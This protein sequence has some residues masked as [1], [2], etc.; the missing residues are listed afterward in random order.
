MSARTLQEPPTEET[1]TTDV[2]RATGILP[3]ARTERFRLLL[4]LFLVYVI[5]GSTYL[6]I[7]LA[8]R[9]LP[10]F[11]MSG[12][13]FLIAG[14]L[15]YLFLRVRGAPSPRRAEW[16][17]AFLVGAFLMGGN[18]GVAFSEQWV[19]S[20]LA[21]LVVAAVPLWVAL[22]SGFWGQWPNRREWL[23][24]GLGLVGIGLLNMESNLRAN[25]LGAVALLLGVVCWA[26]G[27]AWGRHLRLPQGLMASAA[28][29][30]TGGALVLILGLLRGERLHHL[31][32]MSS[33]LALL[34]L[35]GFG[36]LLA[37]S[38]Y[39]YLLRHARPALATSYAYANP[40]IAV[41][42]GAGLAGEKITPVGL[43]ALLVILA[44]VTLMAW[45]KQDRVPRMPGRHE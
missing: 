21:S 9:D 8:V 27:S 7:R 26:W 30:L 13:R 24:L 39:D 28:E 11:L 18:A 1:V 37:F 17:G 45:S 2:P 40:V 36:S 32:D 44:G 12:L 35:I 23:G 31:P 3:V 34:Y 5:W 38:A 19:G 43:L 6:A 41:L 20:G 29:M 10:P 22:F 16:K 25:P 15:L 14:S 4:S 33:V 42:L